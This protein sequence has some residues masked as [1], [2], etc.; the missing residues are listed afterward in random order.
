MSILLLLRTRSKLNSNEKSKKTFFNFEELVFV[1]G[2]IKSFCP[3]SQR[4]KPVFILHF[5]TDSEAKSHML[6]KF[7]NLL[8]SND[9]IV[10]NILIFS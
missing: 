8:D 2:Y 5:M 7:D 1:T 10:N 3:F 4:K 6:A 9:L